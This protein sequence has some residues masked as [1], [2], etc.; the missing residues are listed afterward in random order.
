MASREKAAEVKDKYSSRL[1]GLPGVTGVG[2]KQDEDGQYVLAVHVTDDV[3]E[4][5][6]RLPE[7]IEGCRVKIEQTGS[8]R[9]F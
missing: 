6:G 2:V 1:L 8:Y 5:R 9:K 4:A 3:E 7:Q